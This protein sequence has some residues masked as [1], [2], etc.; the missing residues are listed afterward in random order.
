MNESY[1]I[2]SI[3]QWSRVRSLNKKLAFLGQCPDAGQVD[4]AEGA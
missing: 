4:S 3:C 2:R 1:D